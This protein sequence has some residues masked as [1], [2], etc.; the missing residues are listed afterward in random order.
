MLNSEFFETVS[1]NCD[2]SDAN[3]WGYFSICSL[4]LRLRELFKI[5]RNLA[6]WDSIKNDEIL[7]WI[8]KKEERWRQLDNAQLVPVNVNYELYSPFDIAEINRFTEK[9]NLVY[10][11]GYALFM[12]PSFFIGSIDRFEK[13]DG[14]NIYFIGREIVRD[15]FSSSG[16]SIEKNIYVRLTNIKYRL[17]ENLQN[18]SRKKESIYKFVISDLGNIDNRQ[19]P[20]NEFKKLVEKYSTIVIYHEIAEQEE[21]FIYWS[22]ILKNCD[23]IK[24]EQIIRGIMDLIADFSQSGPLQKSII[25]K[26]R[27]LLG[28]YLLSVDVYKKKLLKF[29]IPQIQEALISIDWETLEKIRKTEFLK[30]KNKLEQLLETYLLKGFEEVKN[31]TNKIFEGG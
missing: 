21:K 19:Y 6:P 13:I 31:L 5:E 7:K 12:K 15:I 1:Y 17:W 8:E 14:Y 16:M 24:T 2:V 28:L 30:W 25:E 20:F 18:W 4:L 27:I 9:Y 11:A 10:G 23:S 3:F 29:S 26:D 22:E